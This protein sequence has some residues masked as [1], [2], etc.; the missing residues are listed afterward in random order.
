MKLAIECKIGYGNSF[1]ALY[2]RELEKSN[3]IFK[4]LFYHS[5]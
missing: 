4:D 5:N 3:N 2:S 1:I